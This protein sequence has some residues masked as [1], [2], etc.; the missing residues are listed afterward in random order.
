MSSSQHEA[1]LPF[2]YRVVRS[3][4]RRT[5]AILIKNDRVE[6]RVPHWVGN[7]WIAAFVHERRDWIATRLSRV[8]LQRELHRPEVRDGGLVPYRGRELRLRLCAGNSSTCRVI[9]DRL[10]V[11]LSQRIRRSAEQVADELVRDWL[12]AR[13][14]EVLP[15]RLQQLSRE[16]GLVPTGVSVRGF[17]RRWGSCDNR[18]GIAL[19]WRLILAEPQAAD[20]VLIHEL[21]HLRHFDHSPRFWQLVGRHCPEHRQWQDYLRE[22]GC[23]LEW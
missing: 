9:D 5:A 18:G 3:R 16:T 8:L 7:D 10:E 13:A 23:W 15:E 2:D 19:N 21:C 4:R 22:R 20:Y 1:P 12:Q 14:R 11:R 17:R 6:V